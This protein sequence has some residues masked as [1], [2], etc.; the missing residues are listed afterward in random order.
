[1]IKQNSL[2]FFLQAVKG[3]WR[4]AIFIECGTCPYG[5]SLCGGYLLAMDSEGRPL[6]VSA[7]EFRKQTNEDIQKEECRSIWK[8]SD[9]ETLYSLWLIWQTDSVR[10]CS[11]L[12]LIQKQT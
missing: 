5:Y 11:V 1:M 8:R 9:F 7:D 12:Q 10:E 2:Y 6:L 4:N 3:D